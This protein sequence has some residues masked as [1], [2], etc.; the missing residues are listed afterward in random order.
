MK[1]TLKFDLADPE[2]HEEFKRAVM[3]LELA[4][5]LFEIREYLLQKRDDGSISDEIFEKVL[6]ILEERRVN[7]NDIYS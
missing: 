5:C 6:E 2:Q 3:S 1:A 7:L 4:G